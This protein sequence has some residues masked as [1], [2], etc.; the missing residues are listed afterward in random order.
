M[1]I[2]KRMYL[3]IASCAIALVI[4]VGV[5]LS[6]VVR[7]YEY[8]NQANVNGI[9]SIMELAKVENYYQKLRLNLL[10]HVSATTQEEK[11]S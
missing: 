2:A 11:D 3:L 4:L 10:R 8:T 7:V 1:T 6:Q 5:A 9:P